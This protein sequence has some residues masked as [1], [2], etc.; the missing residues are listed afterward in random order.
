MTPT[1]LL[2]HAVVPAAV[3]VH[4]T[5]DRRGTCR[6]LL[7]ALCT[8][9]LALAGCGGGGGGTRSATPE[10]RQRVAVTQAIDAAEIAVNALTDASST[11]QLQAAEAAVDAATDAVADADALSQAENRAHTR[12]IT[13]IEDNLAAKRADI[14]M[15][16]AE[17]Q[18]RNAQDVAMLRS[19]LEGARIRDISATV[20]HGA[21]PAM[22]GTVPGNPETDLM[23]LPTTVVA[24]TVAT[25]GGWS[26]GAYEAADEAAGTAD[27]VVFYTDIEA[28]GTQPFGGD[29][30]K[31]G[32]AD[33]I[34][35]DGDLVIR[36]TT[37]A[38]LIAA[39]DFPTGPGIRTHMA[40]TDG[41]VEVAGTF[42][43]AR[44]TFVCTPSAESCTSSIKDGG[45]I[46]LAGGGGWKFVPAQ[47]ATVMKPDTEY[48]YFGWWLRT[49][50]TSHVGAAFHGGVGG[51]A[52]EFASFGALQGQATY[53]G[54]AVGKFIVDPQL[55]DAT[56]GDFTA[57]AT[58]AVNFADATDP[59]TVAG[60]VN[61]FMVNGEAMPWSVELRSAR[62]EANGVIGDGATVWS[63]DGREG[64]AGGSPTWSGRFHE[65]DQDQVPTVAT[66]TFESVFGDIGLMSGAFG[67]TREP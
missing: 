60:A 65:A 34:D 53:S 21:A 1:N 41:M 48:R 27:E 43:G 13:L 6:Y 5:P 40:G 59:G 42:D 2:L 28:P 20:E 35:S 55:D 11:A 67:T 51:D 47:D 61:G 30:G 64:A 8:L 17:R 16:Q 58:L 9:A 7:A 52:L 62:I 31:Y 18:R 12:A 39:P 24:G 45:G 29:M 44:G 57:S 10:E 23:D 33:G 3:S 32:P 15:A 63:I 22:T 4:S 19:V 49:S 54:P 50:A 38:T 26:S 66:G 14:E 56:A 37:D 46:D 36:D 25:A